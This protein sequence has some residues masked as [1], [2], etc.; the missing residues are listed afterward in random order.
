MNKII[1]LID[2]K[3]TELIEKLK[4]LEKQFNYYIKNC[5][6]K[7]NYNLN[8]EFND[9]DN[10][11]I[12]GESTLDMI[13]EEIERSNELFNL[14]EEILKKL[15]KIRTSR[16]KKEIDKIKKLILRSYEKRI[17]E[18]ELLEKRKQKY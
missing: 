12:E 6:I 9:F 1:E 11:I 5:L 3:H 13:L 14:L 4:Q 10:K 17:K 18:R 2:P 16:N 8:D 7:L 15:Q